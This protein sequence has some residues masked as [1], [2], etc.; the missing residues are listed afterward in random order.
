M[1]L[2]SIEAPPPAKE[3]VGCGGGF[4][5]MPNSPSG[6]E[7]G[8]MLWGSERERSDGT[9]L[10]PAVEV[11]IICSSNGVLLSECTS[12]SGEPGVMASYISSGVA[13][14]ESVPLMA[15]L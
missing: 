9:F 15:V 7:L 12:E 10:W 6:V 2:L 3:E 11:S 13:G 8:F 1:M 5:A 4:L 14:I